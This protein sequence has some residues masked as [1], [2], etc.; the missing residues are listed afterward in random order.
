MALKIAS[1]MKFFR[2]TALGSTVLPAGT[3]S[4]AA[5]DTSFVR[6]ERTA[7]RLS[8]SGMYSSGLFRKLQSVPAAETNRPEAITRAGSN[9]HF[10]FIG[11][12]PFIRE[13]HGGYTPETTARKLGLAKFGKFGVRH[14]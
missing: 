14:L 6:F 9:N 13:T 11:L 8:T 12:H 10:V 5:I 1:S 7:C 4:N 3:T 2:G